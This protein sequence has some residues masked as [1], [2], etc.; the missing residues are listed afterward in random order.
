MELR[1]IEVEV[2][3]LVPK[4]HKLTRNLSSVVASILYNPGYIVFADLSLAEKREIEALRKRYNHLVVLA[5][6]RGCGTVEN[7]IKLDRK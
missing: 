2:A 4:T 6:E 7:R 1:H 5:T 3:E